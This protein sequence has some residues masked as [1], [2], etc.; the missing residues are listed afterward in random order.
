[1]KFARPVLHAIRLRM[2]LRRR[3]LATGGWWLVELRPIDGS[4]VYR[5]V[6][7]ETLGRLLR[8]IRDE[9]RTE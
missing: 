7:R 2:R 4:P 5:Q 6:N 1:M 9:H 8:H 3:W